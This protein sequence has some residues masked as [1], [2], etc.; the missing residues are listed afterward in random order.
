MSPI[1]KIGYGLLALIILAIALAFHYYLPATEKVK[2]VGTEV[3]RM[4]KKK[5]ETTETR[6]IRF[7]VT[8]ELVTDE[9]MMFRNEDMPW[10]PYFKF[11]SGSLSGK[12][13]TMK[14]SKPDGV[15]LVTYY[16]WRIPLIS[17]YPNATDL[18]AVDRNY[19]HMPWF[20][21]VFLS[22]LFVFL[23]WGFLRLRGT[24]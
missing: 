19:E 23:L 24:L 2:L 7:I 12:A 15:V 10:P 1:K 20:N 17:L 4:D 22:L 11:D 8:R 14:E 9:T 21:I 13:M 5:G 16:G 18:D 6:D 3:K